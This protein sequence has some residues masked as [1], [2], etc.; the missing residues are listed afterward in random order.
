MSVLSIAR[1]HR[2][3]WSSM[4]GTMLSVPTSGR[5]VATVA[6]APPLWANVF[7]RMFELAARSR[8]RAATAAI[9]VYGRVTAFPKRRPFATNL[10]LSFGA[11]G[12]GDYLAQQAEGATQL[13]ARR[14]AFLCAFGLWTGCLH[15]HLYINVFGKL[16]PQAL[17]FANK[18]LKEK[19]A[20]RAGQ[21]EL[22]GQVA[23]DTAVWMPAFYFPLFYTFKVLLH[24]DHSNTKQLIDLPTAAIEKYST[25]LLEDNLASCAVWIPGD[26]LCFMVPVWLRMPTGVMLNFIWNS[27]LSLMRNGSQHTEEMS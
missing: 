21:R 4:R 2:A 15:W 16:F 1:C 14:T 12:A 9:R 11:A 27:L 22:V 8:N 5:R 26:F 20:D 17:P 23:L 6:F 18:S 7:L 24:T 10:A 13:D 25:T 19:F 3:G